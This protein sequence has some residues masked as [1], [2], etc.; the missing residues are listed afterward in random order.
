[1]RKIIVLG[2]GV[3]ASAL[4]L[5]VTTDLPNRFA[6]A[7]SKTAWFG[8]DT[9]E[10]REKRSL[11]FRRAYA[12]PDF[13]PLSLRLPA[14]E[15][16][17]T[18]IKGE[19]VHR[20]LAKI[21]E[22][23]EQNR[24]AGERFW[25]RIAGS[26]AEEATAAYMA[27]KFRDF[28][29]K[30]VR[31]ENVQGKNQWWPTDW[32]VTLLA[33][34]SYGEGSQDVVLESAFPAIQLE[35]GALSVENLEAE[36]VYVG[37]GHPIDLIGR[38]L[39]GKVAVMHADLQI[40]PF[41]QTARGHVQEVVE[42]GAAAVLTVMQAPGNH[43]YTLEEMGRADVPTII[44]GGDDGRFVE[45]VIAAAAGTGPVKVR[46]KYKAEVREPW[47]GKNVIGVIPGQTDEYVIVI[48]HL[49]GY[50][51]SANDNAGGLASVLS[52]AEHYSRPGAA[53]PRR[54]ILFLGSSAHHEFSDG[55]EAFIASHK[56]I[57]E[58][59]VLV[60]N[61]EHPSSIMSYYRG[62]LKFYRFTV[63][64]E[65]ATM[66]TDGPRTLTVSN[67]NELLIKFYRDAIDRYGLAI[68]SKVSPA[69][70]SGDA[71][72][73]FKAGQTVLQILDANLWYHS[74]GDT[75]DSIHPHGL[76]RA[77]RLYAEVLDRIDSTPTADLK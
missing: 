66:T 42:A 10:V 29:L 46:I 51:E 31:L 73:F 53:K 38:D 30:D 40:D 8:V 27:Q 59:T 57:L 63:P 33:Q 15:D 50:F 28:G 75:I 2:L 23:T 16:P 47:Q 74:S 43:Q 32:K 72:P 24:P 5:L 45:D 4:L 54:G 44:L 67:G 12:E 20:Y 41:F 7:A 64:G 34:P 39:R 48:A 49:D 25:G 17:Y 70:P 37:H 19:D 55:A 65:L 52:L 18:D 22:I 35:K 77:T 36:L 9:P 3:A 6:Q 56:D 60:V 1:M 71:Y 14:S 68:T 61:V 21:I 62:E 58:K 13:P 69:P 26:E 11:K 76:E